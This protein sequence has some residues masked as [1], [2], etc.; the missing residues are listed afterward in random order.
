MHPR[1]FSLVFGYLPGIDKSYKPA[2][3]QDLHRRFAVV[4][5]SYRPSLNE[6]YYD[7]EMFFEILNAVASLIDHDELTVSYNNKTE[8]FKTIAATKAEQIVRHGMEDD[9][10]DR[11]E[12]LKDRLTACIV[13]PEP[14]YAIGGLE[15]YH[16]SFTFAFY[17]KDDNRDL[18]LAALKDLAIEKNYILENVIVGNELP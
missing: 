7:W 9:H 10:F 6:M 15:P 18:F 1:S 13:N 5:D 12:F 4:L 8:H 16:D 11:L 14:Y 2:L 17:L 3:K